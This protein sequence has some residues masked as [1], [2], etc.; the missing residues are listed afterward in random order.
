MHSTCKCT[1]NSYN[2][3]VHY[4]LHAYV[5][6]DQHTTNSWHSQYDST[7]LDTNTDQ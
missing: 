1:S 4:I 2:Y 7:L 5:L 6:L 3:N